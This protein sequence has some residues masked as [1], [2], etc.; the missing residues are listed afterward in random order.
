MYV[1]LE[2]GIKHVAHEHGVRLVAHAKHVLRA[3]VAEALRRGLQ[4]VER[5]AQVTLRR[6]HHGR[7][8]FFSV[9]QLLLF[10]HLNYLYCE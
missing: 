3:D 9:G 5:G 8:A 2:A 10:T 4:V 1:L 7:Y 6:E